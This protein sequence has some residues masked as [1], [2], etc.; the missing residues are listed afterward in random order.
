MLDETWRSGGGGGKGSE[1]WSARSWSGVCGVYGDGV[2]GR[3]RGYLGG[4]SRVRFAW[5]DGRVAAHIVG[6]GVEG[7]RGAQSVG[8]DATTVV[9]RSSRRVAGY[10]G[11]VPEA[12]GI[13]EGEGGSRAGLVA[14]DYCMVADRVLGGVEVGSEFFAVHLVT[15]RE[16]LAALGR[17]CMLLNMVAEHYLPVDAVERFPSL[18]SMSLL[19]F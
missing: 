19:P 10:G 7:G 12:V 5:A 16:Q 4:L 15:A 8:V 11:A 17:D 6:R 18:G 13:V 14:G 9:S 1:S 3:G 2:G